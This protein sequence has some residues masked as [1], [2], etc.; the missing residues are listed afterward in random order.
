MGY[1]RSG[2]AVE[3]IVK[4]LEINYKIYDSGKKITG[5]NYYSRLSKKI[6]RSFD[7]LV[8]SPGISIYNKYVTY[9]ERLG[10]KVVGELEFGYWFT[11]SP[12]VAVTGTNGK[13]TTTRLINDMI[14]TTYHSETYGNI[15]E[16]LS[17]A[18]NCKQDYLVCEVS[19]FQLESTYSFK[20]YISVLLNIA[21][22]HIDRHK[23]FENY[24][25]CKLGL[26]KNCTEK[27][28]V[29]LNA[30]DKIIME[31]TKDLNAKK[32]YISR[33][34]KVK[35]VYFKD[36]KIYSNLT[37][38]QLIMELPSEDR[39]IAILEDILASILVS[40]LLR[41]DKEKIVD[42]VL[43]F[44]VSPHRLEEVPACEGKRCIDDSKS[45]NI[46]STVNA[47]DVVKGKVI[48]L[49]GGE[50]KNLDFGEIFTK[51][52]DKLSHI[53]AFGSARKKIL[54]TAKRFNYTSI[55]S[56]KTFTQAVRSA[57]DIV[58]EGE[59]ILLSPGCTSFDEFHSYAE[60]GEKFASLI[61]E[62]SNAK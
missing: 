34:S 53:I 22:D 18:F 39:Y 13:T 12:V 8:L 51:F 43:D 58:Q 5:G 42:R 56:Y 16:P 20:P 40:L 50:D 49:L 27:S 37:T 31:R 29:V 7:L 47:L 17:L 23:T 2:R 45:T 24:I 35:G 33:F 21:K 1:G 41:I 14:G 19:S 38:N 62:Y 9:A 61:K 48:L 57:W 10:I 36:G 44:K 55:D 52:N 3:E 32:Y 11:S 30:D 28:I 59:T 6:V 15:G 46:H 25:K 54:K 60:R 4:K 26:L